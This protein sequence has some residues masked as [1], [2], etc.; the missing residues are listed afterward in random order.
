MA[1]PQVPDRLDEFRPATGPPKGEDR[2]NGEEEA[3]AAPERGLGHDVRGYPSSSPGDLLIDGS[4]AATSIPD[5]NL[6]RF[7]RPVNPAVA[8]AEHRQLAV[9]RVAR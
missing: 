3:S 1:Y 9:I 6:G 8:V 7:L 2:P 5:S 4:N